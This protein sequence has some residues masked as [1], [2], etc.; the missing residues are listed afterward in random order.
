VIEMLAAKFFG[1]KVN[2]SIDW[3]AFFDSVYQKRAFHYHAEGNSRRFSHLVD[4]HSI[5]N[6]LNW[7]GE[8]HIQVGRRG[9]SWDES[10]KDLSIPFSRGFTII[11]NSYDYAPFPAIRIFVHGISC[12]LEMPVSI[13]AFLTPASSAGFDW[14]YDYADALVLQVEGSKEWEFANPVTDL[15]LKGLVLNKPPE[16]VQTVV[17]DPGDILYL[18]RGYPHRAMAQAELSLHLTVNL[19]PIKRYEVL[20]RAVKILAQEDPYL[21]ADWTPNTDNGASRHRS[22]RSRSSVELQR[23][24]DDLVHRWVC[25][26]PQLRDIRPR[27]EIRIGRRSKFHKVPEVL[28][29][30]SID[31]SSCRLS[32][33]GVGQ[34]D[35]EPLTFRLPFSDLAPFEL[36][37]DSIRAFNADQ[38]LTMEKKF[39][40][41]LIGDFI[42]VGLLEVVS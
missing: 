18:P 5:L 20:N 26:L 41:E 37:L 21:R 7:T 31:E 1:T 30:V 32:V 12:A 4:V 14:H 10:K 22:F 2:L 16:N 17:L 6:S 8:E 34:M 15:P 3:S 35:E 24:H 28:S 23:A 33:G 29:Y 40:E 25:D 27:S 9:T 36:S 38:A 42:S 13:S 19:I 11:A 39:T